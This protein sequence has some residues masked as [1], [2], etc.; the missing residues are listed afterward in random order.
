MERKMKYKYVH[1]LWNSDTHIKFYSNLVNLINN[2]LCREEHLFVAIDKEV[3]LKLSKWENVEFYHSRCPESSSIVRYC[4]HKGQWV[5]LHGIRASV[6]I[7]KP[8]DY[9]RVIWRSWG[10]G[11][12]F[13]YNEG[14]HIKN[15]LKRILAPVRK[16]MVRNFYAVG[17][18]NAVDDIDVRQAF[19]DVNTVQ[20]NYTSSDVDRLLEMVKHVAHKGS[21]INIMVG[22]SGRSYDNH[23]CVLESLRKFLKEDILIHLILSYGDSEY[24]DS[25]EEYVH[26]YWPEKIIIHKEFMELEDYIA[27]LSK[28]D[29]AIFDGTVSYA[30]ANIE[31][32]IEMEKTIVLNRYGV[33]KK[34]FDENSIP[35]VC[36]DCLA[37]MSLEELIRKRDFSKIGDGM[38]ILSYNDVIKNWNDFFIELDNASSSNKV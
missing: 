18:A 30:L 36:S 22:H 3:Y 15:L 37:T 12:Q 26:R 27:F 32:M 13:I 7:L 38:K 11:V 33:I 17:I 21:T 2:N 31:W 28:M 35:Y 34:A 10:G 25:V 5:I 6:L 24:M 8:W 1:A 20:L 14:E 4:L 16:H 19:G 29:I 23:I 9:K